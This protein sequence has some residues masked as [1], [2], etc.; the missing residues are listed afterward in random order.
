VIGV[1]QH[2]LRRHAGF[3]PR[4]KPELIRL[5]A[6]PTERHLGRPRDR[7]AR[8]LLLRSVLAESLEDAEIDLLRIS[9]E[10]PQS[11]VA[12]RALMRLAEGRRLLR[13]VPAYWPGEGKVPAKCSLLGSYEQMGP[14]DL[15]QSGQFWRAFSK[16]VHLS[17][18][19]T[20]PTEAPNIG[21]PTTCS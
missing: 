8:A 7:R 19:W 2:L 12:D 1:S 21:S 10:H 20:S 14:A 4:A 18:T 5:L 6:S 15:D 9:V 3:F 16:H 11:P 13:H 17:G